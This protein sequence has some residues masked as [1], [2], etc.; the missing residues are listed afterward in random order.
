MQRNEEETRADLIDPKINECGWTASKSEC[1][2]YRNHPINRGRILVGNKRARPL[3]SDYVLSFK[4]RKLAV[5]EAK[6]E[7][8]EYTKG[9]QQAKNYARLLNARFAY[10][11][12]GKKIYQVDMLTGEEKDVDNYPSPEKIWDMT[13]SSFSKDV[14]EL[15]ST[16]L[17]DCGGTYEDR[18][19]SENAVNK[20]LDSI[21]SKQKKILLTLATGTGKTKIAFQIAWKLFKNKWSI[22]GFGS[23]EPKILFLV[24]RNILAD[25]A[26]NEFNQ[27]PKNS[28]VRIKPKKIKTDGRVPT[29]GSVFFTIFQ[30][31]LTEDKKTFNFFKYPKDFFDLII[32]DECHRGGANDQS[33]WRE[34]LNYFNSSYQLG[35]T[36]TPKRDDNVDTYKYFGEPVFTYSLKDGIIDG[37]LTPYKIKQIHSPESDEYLYHED[38]EIIEGEIEENRKYTEQEINTLIEIEEREKK[39]VDQ[40]MNLIEANEK[41]LIFCATQ[42]HAL[43]IRNLVNK[44][45]KSN[46]PDYCVRVTADDGDLGETYLNQFKDNDNNIPTILTTSRKL[47]TGV[48]ARNVR[49]IILL[50]K[51]KTIIEFKQIV[52]RGTRLFD[53]KDFF[54]IYD[55]VSAYE[56]FKDPEWD[57]EPI[58]PEKPENPKKPTII[59]PPIKKPEPR[60]IIEV[61]LS[62]NRSKKIKFNIET[63]Y[64]DKNGNIISAVEYLKSFFGELPKLFK[65]EEELREIWSNPLTRQDLLS[66]LS[67]GGFSKNELEQ[68]QKMTDNQ[69]SDIYDV[70]NYI[71]FDRNP[72]LREERIYN[73]KKYFNNN[74]KESQK[75]FIDFTLSKYLVDGVWELAPDKLPSLIE[76]KYKDHI[77]AENNLGDPNKIKETF[78]GFQRYLY[79]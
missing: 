50:R 46:D 47:S 15:I 59:K 6:K 73:A 18:Y 33:S 53:G 30:T 43:I 17:N 42:R 51:I 38:D 49:N 60:K 11:T 65:K 77:E 7:S 41:T 78:Y 52:G 37:F 71:S 39:R 19:Y 22:D 23:K 48:D 8:D 74:Y 54:T 72:K 3:E 79:I 28:L 76:L 63:K 44:V 25:Q 32:V 61:K 31:F 75:D 27:F 13:F 5:I 67:K 16:P 68:L 1:R 35:L 64:Y 29:N 4:N 21:I 45:K 34:I 24:D 69:Y 10:S 66:N 57:G 2:V 58:D 14:Q 12:N 70:L 40:F 9:L 26:M 36:A 62:D 55:F 56:H 20:V